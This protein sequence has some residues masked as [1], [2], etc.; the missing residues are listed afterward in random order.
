[1]K[2]ELINPCA[3]PWCRETATHR[4]TRDDNTLSPLEVCA[5]CVVWARGQLGPE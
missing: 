3:Q 4:V 2:V 5:G 1:M